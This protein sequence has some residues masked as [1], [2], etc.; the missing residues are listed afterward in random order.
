M[1]A[2]AAAAALVEFDADLR[3][4]VD[5]LNARGD[6]WWIEPGAREDQEDVIRQCAGTWTLSLA[7]ASAGVTEVQVLTALARFHLRL[8]TQK[9]AAATVYSVLKNNRAD[10]AR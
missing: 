2:K 1:T 10:C 7:A 4:R 3:A 9:C 5:A 6:Y 8:G